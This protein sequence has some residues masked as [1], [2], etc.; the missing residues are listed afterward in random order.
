M[1]RKLCAVSHRDCSIHFRLP[2]DESVA[3]VKTV[4]P[5]SAQSNLPYHVDVHS[6]PATGGDVIVFAPA[7]SR[8]AHDAVP[9]RSSSNGI[10]LSQLSDFIYGLPPM[11][12]LGT[13]R[14]SDRHSP[15]R[16]SYAL[17]RKWSVRPIGG[18]LSTSRCRTAIRYLHRTRICR[19]GLP[20][21]AVRLPPPGT[22]GVHRC[23]FGGRDHHAGN[24][25]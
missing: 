11:L 12:S 14:K 17:N 8:A 16:S 21:I 13:G 9:N 23:G 18:R 15:C 2:L 1:H 22:L 19:T 10:G 20:C 4:A 7:S 24:T 25:R 6:S 3:H 5:S